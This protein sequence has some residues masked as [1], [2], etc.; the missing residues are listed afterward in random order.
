MSMDE[1]NVVAITSVSVVC[2]PKI[3]LSVYK[4]YLSN[5][6]VLVGEVDSFLLLNITLFVGVG[7]LFSQ[8][9]GK[10]MSVLHMLSWQSILYRVVA[11]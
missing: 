5:V 3:K 11:Y 1:S 4:G 7:I 10:C 2:K 9:S 8:L 6:T